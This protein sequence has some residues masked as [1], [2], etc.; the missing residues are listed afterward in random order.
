MKLALFFSRNISLKTWVDT[1]LFYREKLLYEHHLQTGICEI[2]YW[3]TYG[4]DDH[5]LAEEL[6]THGKLDPR[7]K[8][9]PRP[10]WFRFPLFCSWLYSLKMPFLFLHLLKK[11]DIMKSNQLDGSQSAWIASFLF[12]KPLYIRCGYMP[13]QHHRDNPQLSRF[14][15][16]YYYWLER[17]MFYQAD[18]AVVSNQ[19]DYPIALVN[20]KKSNG[21]SILPN[22]VDTSIFKS[23]LISRKQT[24]N[25]V[26]VG[27]FTIEKNL[28]NLLQACMISGKSLTLIGQGDQ[29][30]ELQNLANQ[31]NIKIDFLPQIPNY[32]LPNTLNQYQ[33]FI[34]PSLYEGL[35]KVL[36]EAMA[37]GLVCIGTNV[38]GIN[39]IITDG[40]N[41]YLSPGTDPQS[42]ART[43]TR[44][45]NA[46]NTSIREQAVK[47]IREKY[48]LDFV[49]GLEHEIFKKLRNHHS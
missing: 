25:L 23:C 34:L 12:H 36:L 42:I 26:F 44:A 4:T 24:N 22:Y 32:K 47:T 17:I 43:I 37:C 39:E 1:G 33:Y 9:I 30:E 7:I 31:L 29:L 5:L 41:G 27:R 19:T 38:T 35:P 49:A 14:Q 40:I 2:I 15:K 21:L 6:H 18:Y 28:F 48:S 13:F 20:R 10:R 45:M 8:V 16:K 11:I 46:N 3:F